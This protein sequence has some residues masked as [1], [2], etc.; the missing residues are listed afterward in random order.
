[1]MPSSLL[2]TEPSVNSCWQ[3]MQMSSVYKSFGLEMK[4]FA[5]CILTCYAVVHPDATVC[6]FF[7]AQVTGTNEAIVSLYLLKTSAWKLKM[8]EIYCF[9]TSEIESL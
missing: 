5:N 3:L 6:A 9:M 7:H 1:M 8:S 4:I 2:G